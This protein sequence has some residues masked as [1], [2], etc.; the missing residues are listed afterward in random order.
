[1]DLT[2]L[3]RNNRQTTPTRSAPLPYIRPRMRRVA[4]LAT[5]TEEHQAI[6]QPSQMLLEQMAVAHQLHPM[7]LTAEE[8]ELMTPIT[9]DDIDKMFDDKAQNKSHQSHDMAS[10]LSALPQASSSP[11]HK[12][13][14]HAATP[15]PEIGSARRTRSMTAALSASVSP[16]MST[17]RLRSSNLASAVRT[18]SPSDL[19]DPESWASAS[20]A[21]KRLSQMKDAGKDWA[22]ITAMWNTET[23]K[24]KTSQEMTKRWRRIKG[25]IGRWPGFDVSNPYRIDDRMFHL[26]LDIWL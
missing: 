6:Q 3:A 26:I 5:T 7:Q 20:V 8:K 22:E 17:R 12:R 9:M 1:M 24:K 14:R 23:G 16:A 11:P 15:S 19:A 21:D 13:A 10:N 4:A 25:K 2:R 18:A